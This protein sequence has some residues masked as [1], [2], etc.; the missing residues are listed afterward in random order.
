MGQER[1]SGRLENTTLRHGVRRDL[2]RQPFSAVLGRWPDADVDVLA[3]VEA[4][5]GARRQRA[6]HVAFA[7]P[8][9]HLAAAACLPTSLRL[10]GDASGRTLRTAGPMTLTLR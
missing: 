2:D 9:L 4:P 10:S 1:E 5:V 3:A 8:G 7:I 6:A